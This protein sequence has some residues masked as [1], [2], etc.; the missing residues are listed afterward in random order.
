MSRTAIRRMLD[1]PAAMPAAGVMEPGRG[2][3]RIVVACEPALFDRVNHLAAAS[4]VSFAEA[5][6]Q[7]LDRGLN[8]SGV[9][10]ER[11]DRVMAS[12]ARGQQPGQA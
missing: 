12:L 8:A 10:R 9:D 11:Y 4:G 1:R 2:F 6:R 5:V 3:K 7:L